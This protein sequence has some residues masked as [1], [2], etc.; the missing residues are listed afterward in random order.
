MKHNEKQYLLIK[1]RLA[2]RAILPIVGLM[3]LSVLGGQSL[4]LDISHKITDL[5]AKPEPIIEVKP[6]SNQDYLIQQ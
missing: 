1:K 6:I 5:L 3:G 4:Y 2:K